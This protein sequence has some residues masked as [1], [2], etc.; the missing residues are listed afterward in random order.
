MFQW[1]T[2]WIFGTTE[3][4]KKKKKKKE[5]K[6]PREEELIHGDVDEGHLWKRPITT[7]ALS[8]QGCCKQPHLHDSRKLLL[9]LSDCEELSYFSYLFLVK[10]VCDHIYR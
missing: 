6:R 5:K 2:S 1:V 4:K 10:W 3:R 7:L 9:S 8:Y